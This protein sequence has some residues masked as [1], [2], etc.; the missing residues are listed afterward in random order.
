MWVQHGLGGD[1]ITWFLPL[2]QGQQQC[3]WLL[4]AIRLVC[5]ILYIP[6]RSTVL[7]DNLRQQRR[8]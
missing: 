4:W 6:S 7:P 5:I 8:G 3:P 1:R 2:G